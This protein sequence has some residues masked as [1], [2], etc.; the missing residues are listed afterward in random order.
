MF[1]VL[2]SFLILFFKGNFR[3]IVDNIDR[4]HMKICA[5][6]NFLH[7]LVSNF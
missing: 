7:S 4:F 1:K 3:K 6:S 5:E 2:F